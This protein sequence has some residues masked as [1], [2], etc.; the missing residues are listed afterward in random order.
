MVFKIKLR[1]Q[2]FIFSTGK[3]QQINLILPLLYILTFS[4]FCLQNIG[5]I[6]TNRLWK[7]TKLLMN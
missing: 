4:G 3:L 2:H 1:E 7:P 6:H 5:V